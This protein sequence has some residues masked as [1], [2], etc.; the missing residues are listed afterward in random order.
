M[1]KN[2]LEDDQR[3][4]YTRVFISLGSRSHFQIKTRTNRW[5]A[6]LHYIKENEEEAEEADVEGETWDIVTAVKI[7]VLFYS[8]FFNFLMNR[9]KRA[10]MFSC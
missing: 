6:L 9:N 3:F 4:F 8:L 10:W 5:D 2:R 7:S 1:T